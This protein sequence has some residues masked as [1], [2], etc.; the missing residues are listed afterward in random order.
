MMMDDIEK[1]AQAMDSSPDVIWGSNGCRS[2]SAM[3]VSDE[4]RAAPQY[5]A[6]GQN[7]HSDT[8]ERKKPD[9]ASGTVN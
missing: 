7:R 8:C 1:G 3:P 4:T 6:K 9:Q 2:T 5:V